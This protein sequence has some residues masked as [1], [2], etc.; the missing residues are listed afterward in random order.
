MPATHASASGSNAPCG[1]SR[2]TGIRR[3]QGMF[4]IRRLRLRK[5]MSGALGPPGVRKR[6]AAAAGTPSPRDCAQ[7][8]KHFGELAQLLES[9]DKLVSLGSAV[10]TEDVVAVVVDMLGAMYIDGL[11]KDHQ[12]K[13]LSLLFRQSTMSEQGQSASHRTAQE[14]LAVRGAAAGGPQDC[15]VVLSLPEPELTLGVALPVARTTTGVA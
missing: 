9:M 2:S 8:A 5:R 13:A 7:R 12:G 6:G 10:T 3:A 11:D 14:D 4:T 1:K 15:F